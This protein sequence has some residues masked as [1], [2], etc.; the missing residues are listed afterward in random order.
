MTEGLPAA[1][2]NL[3]PTYRTRDGSLAKEFFEPCL[4]HCTTYSRAAGYFSSSALKTWSGALQRIVSQQV[5]VRLLISPELSHEDAEVFRQTAD[6]HKRRA[7]L[8]QAAETLLEQ[9]LQ[10]SENPDNKELRLQL[11][12]WM[13]AAGQLVIKFAIPKHIEDAGI[14]HEKSG[15]FYFPGAHRVAFEGSANETVSGHM[16]NYEKVQVFRSWVSADEPRVSAVEEDFRTQ[17]DGLDETLL[18][19]PISL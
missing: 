11:F 8:E 18:V 5:E 9:T 6:D 16:R 2:Q 10:F 17:W 3:K 14:F 4:R 19:V 13:I 1:I 12:A 15:I 7:I